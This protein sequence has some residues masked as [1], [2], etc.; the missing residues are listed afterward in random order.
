MDTYG[1]LDLNDEVY[2]WGGIRGTVFDRHNGIF[3]ITNGQNTMSVCAGFKLVKPL[4][5]FV[6][7]IKT[8]IC[9]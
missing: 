6:Y 1:S 5:S 3:A 8:A 4:N 9:I 7:Y 2:L